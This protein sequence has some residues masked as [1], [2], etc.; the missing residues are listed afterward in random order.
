MPV[1]KLL[2]SILESIKNSEVNLPVL[3]KQSF[4]GT[5][6]W[7]KG[8][9]LFKM[10]SSL[11]VAPISWEFAEYLLVWWVVSYFSSSLDYF[12]KAGEFIGTFLKV[13]KSTDEKYALILSSSF[14]KF[15]WIDLL[16]KWSCILDVTYIY[17]V[18]F[19]CPVDVMNPIWMS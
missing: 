14:L 7:H 2:L 13:V 17:D 1:F 5:L 4:K 8:Y 15:K 16:F 19:N 9:Y 10:I 18:D 6:I 12:K 11:E 3:K